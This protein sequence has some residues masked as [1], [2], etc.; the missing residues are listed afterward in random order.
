MNNQAL[1][2]LVTGPNLISYIETLSL[3]DHDYIADTNHLATLSADLEHDRYT[4]QKSWF[5][6]YIHTLRY[7]GWSLYKDSTFT[8]T[9]HIVTN[10]VADFLVESADA[11]KDFRQANAMIDTL[12]AMKS[13]NPAML[14]FDK[15]SRQGESFQVVPARY[16]SEGNLHIA[17]YKLELRVRNRSSR[18][19][20]WNLEEHSARIIQ[21]KAY[22]RLDRKEMARISEY[23]KQK[24]NGSLMRRFALRKHR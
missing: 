11:M 17:F 7:M 2:G 18:F 23:I 22:M 10:S 5:D 3:Q 6:S 8:S 16:D 15:E 19:L 24:A 1:T 12:Q 4:A 9:R 14:S 21:H 13:D 20:F